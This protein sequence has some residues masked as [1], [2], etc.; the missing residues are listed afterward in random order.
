MSKLGSEAAW[1]FLGQLLSLAGTLIG[2]RI[3]TEYL[4]P[5]AYGTLGLSLTIAALFNE[6]VIGGFIGAFTRFYSIA[7]AADDVS[8]YVRGV[9]WLLL[10]CAGIAVLLLAAVFSLMLS[11]FEGLSWQIALVVT[12]FAV[13]FGT[14]AAMNAVFNGARQRRLVALNSVVDAWLK[15]GFAVLAINLF[16]PDPVTVLTA[17]ALSLMLVLCH[18][19]YRLKRL[20]GDRQ[21]AGT[22]KNTRRWSKEMLLFAAPASAWGIF[23]WAQQVADRWSLQTFYSTAEVGLYSV[24]LQLGYFPMTLLMGMLGTFLTP[25]FF[26]KTDD[27]TKQISQEQNAWW[28]TLSL[29]GAGFSL[30]AAGMAFLLKDWV[31]ALLVSDEYWVVSPYLPI[32]VLAGGLFGTGSL[33]SVRLMSHMRMIELAK[34]MIGT[35]IFGV[36]LTAALTSMFG[37]VGTV[38][39]KV[40]FA[41]SYIA[42][43]VWVTIFYK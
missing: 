22:P 39:A 9:K 31:F 27:Q 8:G 17:Y 35:A 7:A 29:V 37:L 10:G 30:V 36:V 13:L 38:L 34:V 26:Q 4:S 28:R 15:I 2:V 5:S 3:L 24:V 32:M 21:V 1:V 42:W 14:N 23:T 33:M 18:Q 25:I 19:F 12:L 16:G 40:L 20:A 11:G 43:M 6:V 41:L